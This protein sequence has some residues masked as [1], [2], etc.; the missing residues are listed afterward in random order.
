MQTA[1]A[2]DEQYHVAIGVPHEVKGH[3]QQPGSTDVEHQRSPLAADIPVLPVLDVRL[4]ELLVWYYAVEEY[5]AKLGVFDDTEKFQRMTS[6]L[7]PSVLNQLDDI[8]T[9]PP[10]THAYECLLIAVFKRSKS[11]R[12][13]GEGVVSGDEFLEE[14]PYELVMK[15]SKVDAAVNEMNPPPFSGE[16][17]GC[18]ACR[19]R[20]R[21]F[22]DTDTYF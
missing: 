9:L 10:P 15:F 1:G 8:L 3:R 13:G 14:L 12:D 21:L 18:C 19:D 11:A 6:F 4:G 7:S 22:G 20:E 5:L 16:E 17:H 2:A